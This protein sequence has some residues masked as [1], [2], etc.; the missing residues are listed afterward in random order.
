MK[1]N[2]MAGSKESGLN[3]L[4][5]NCREMKIIYVKQGMASHLEEEIK[6]NDKSSGPGETFLYKIS[7]LK[8]AVK[9]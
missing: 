5:C 6:R 2:K 1:W 9:Q 7:E 3:T 4:P 8:D